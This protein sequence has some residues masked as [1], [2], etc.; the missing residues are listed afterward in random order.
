MKISKFI[1]GTGGFHSARENERINFLSEVVNNGFTHF[2]TSPLYNYGLSEKDI[3]IMIKKNKNLTV[4]TK[5]GLYPPTSSRPNLL[6]I[7]LR[8]SFGKLYPSLSK[9][10]VDY[11]LDKAKKSLE[12]SSKRLNKEC[13]DILMIHEPNLELLDTEEWIRWFE[14]LISEGKIRYYGLAISNPLKIKNFFK[15]IQSRDSL[16]SKELD[17]LSNNQA[18][19]KI[20]FGYFNDL[21]IRNVEINSDIIIK[22]ILKKNLKNSI[23]INTNNKKKLKNF[24]IYQTTLDIRI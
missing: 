4:T 5:V 1:Y 11:S 16:F 8:K 9:T 22:K 23:I 19:F 20:N 13:I 14:N 17:Y 12:K 18:S 2:D 3:G 7:F 6:N 21:K 10:V 24:G 15:I